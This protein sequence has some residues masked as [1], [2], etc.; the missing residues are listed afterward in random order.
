MIGFELTKEQKE[1]Q[2]KARKFA[3]EEILP[4]SRK[5]DISGEF[6]WELF[7]KAFDQGL[8][9]TLIPKEYGGPGGS[10]LESC[11]LVEEIAAADPGIATSFFA[12]N[13]GSEPIIIGGTDEQKKRFLTPLTQKL[14]FIAFAT[15]EPAMGSDVAGIQTEA[16]KVDGG[17]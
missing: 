2:Q 9:N 1:I 15:S 7:Q 11:I 13:L 10:L 4:I 17:Y 14:S 3:I 12:N 5:Y 8:L 6:P 16:K